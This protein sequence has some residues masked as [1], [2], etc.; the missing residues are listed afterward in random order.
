MHQACRGSG[1]RILVSGAGGVMPGSVAGQAPP[2]LLAPGF[3]FVDECLLLLGAFDQDGPFLGAGRLVPALTETA[4]QVRDLLPETC[5]VCLDDLELL[6]DLGR[7]LGGAH[8]WRS[9]RPRPARPSDAASRSRCGT[10]TYR[11]SLVDAVPASKVP[12]RC[13]TLPPSRARPAVAA[14]SRLRRAT[15]TAA[16]APPSVSHSD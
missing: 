9:P 10:T 4:P 6:P 2:K 5:Q 15:E 8:G 1:T 14:A 11:G 13:S 12:K 7:R 16:T 3:Q